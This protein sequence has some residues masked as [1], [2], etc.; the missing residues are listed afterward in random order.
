MRWET[1]ADAQAAPVGG[2]FYVGRVE[3]VGEDDVVATLWER[4][5]GREA[6]TALSVTDHLGGRKPPPGSLLR[7]WTWVELP[8]GDKQVPRIKVKIEEPRVTEEGRKQ[9][10][11][12]AESL[13]QR[14]PESLT[15]GTLEPTDEA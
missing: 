11:D 1:L 13:K 12:I 3:E 10:L 2:A 15:L 9:L 8:G 4:P 5:S 6:S 7:I 14:V